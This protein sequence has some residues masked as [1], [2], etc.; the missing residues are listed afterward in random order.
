MATLARDVSES[1]DPFDV[2]RS[3]LYRDDTW[4]EPFARLR[5]EAPVHYVHDSE[6]GPY[7]SVSSYK[8]I[9]EVESLPDLYS[10]EAGG[11][12][13][14]DFDATDPNAVRMPMFIARDRPVHTA[15]RR[16]VA[17]AFTPS[18]MTRLASDIRRRTEEVLD[19]LPWGERFDWVDT[20]SIE[21]T[22]Q[23]LAILFD[24]PWEDRRKLTFWSDW[25]GDIEIIK[26]E[27][28]RQQR[29][30]HMYECGTYFRRLWN[31]KLNKPLQPDLISMMIHSDAMREMDDNE[32]LGNLILLI[33]GG[34]DTTRNTMSGLAYGLDKYPDQRAKLE[35]DPSLIPNAV[36]EI[37]R[38]Q[39]PLAHMRRTATQDTELMGQ[40]IK[41]GDKL[42]LW[43]ISGNRDE[44]VFGEDADKLIVDRPNARRHLAF[45]HGIHRCV[46]ARLAELQIGILLEEMAKRRMRVNVAGAPERVSACFVH[47][48]R[49]LPVE[50]S[51]Y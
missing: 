29:L 44:S 7:W 4:R 49:K 20:V 39:T 18:E 37:I 27:D 22:T 45:G 43:Y 17:P 36:S 28:L 38:W 30:M 34:N 19:S 2:S 50:L 9:V 47:G 12:T 23:M 42:A 14:A 13:I 25:A 8:P 15:Q 10:S 11:I 48:Y 40:Q 41:A 32:F 31:E 6:F 26:N 35:A 1:V 16:T 51:K 3:E 5:A 21:L 46:G 24:F 33:V